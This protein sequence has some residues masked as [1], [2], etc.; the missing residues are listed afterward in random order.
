MKIAEGKDI[1]RKLKDSIDDKS[2]EYLS[3][4]EIFEIL[5]YRP[6]LKED[7][8]SFLNKFRGRIITPDEKFE[9]LKGLNGILCCY[10]ILDI[11]AVFNVDTNDINFVDARML[12]DGKSQENAV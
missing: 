11:K 7:I 10:E 8:S 6:K 4:N 2:S 1:F 5:T 9:I 12:S 3:R